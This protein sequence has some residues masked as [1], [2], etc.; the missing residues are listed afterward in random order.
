MPACE[1]T[2]SCVLCLVTVYYYNDLRRVYSKLGNIV[3]GNFGIRVASDKC[4]SRHSL[5]YL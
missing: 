3:I 1:K 2:G 5:Q 4:T